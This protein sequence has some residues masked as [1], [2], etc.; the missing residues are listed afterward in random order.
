MR[1]SLSTFAK[2]RDRKKVARTEGPLES[3]CTLIMLSY[4]WR[5]CLQ[6]LK[7]SLDPCNTFM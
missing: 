1:H 7:I 6:K 4:R 2:N 5:H 3:V